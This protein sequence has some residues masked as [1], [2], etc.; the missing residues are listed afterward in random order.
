MICVVA[1]SPALESSL[2]FKLSSLRAYT[3]LGDYCQAHRMRYPWLYRSTDKVAV[4]KSTT[5]FADII[6]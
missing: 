5:D 1:D 3:D 6:H 4:P 2:G